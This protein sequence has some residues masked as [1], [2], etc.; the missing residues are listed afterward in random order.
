MCDPGVGRPGRK[1]PKI[2]REAGDVG[3]REKVC[4]LVRCPY[5]KPTQ[6]DEER[7]LRPTGEGLLRNSAKL[8]RNFGIRG[9]PARGPQRIGPSDCLPKTQV[10]AKSKDDVYGL[11][12]ARC[13]KVKRRG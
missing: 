5:R 9:A 1:G 10:Y 8:P 11:T 2:S 7:I 6:V 13:W 3:R 4:E 12:P